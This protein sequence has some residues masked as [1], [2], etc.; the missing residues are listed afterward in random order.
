MAIKI[1]H[2]TKTKAKLF[3]GGQPKDFSFQPE[4]GTAY[5]ISCKLAIAGKSYVI[6][7]T[8]AIDA[9]GLREVGQHFVELADMMEGKVA[10]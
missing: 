10:A 4:T 2:E 5:N 7:A 6:G 3:T 8:G 9:K 1:S